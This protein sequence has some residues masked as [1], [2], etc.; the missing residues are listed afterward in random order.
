MY[1]RWTPM[2]C[3]VPGG[4][5]AAPVPDLRDLVEHGAHPA[6]PEEGAPE[7]VGVL[8]HRLRELV[9]QQLPRRRDLGAVDVADGARVEGVGLVDLVE[10]LRDDAEVVG[11]V[12][13]Q[14]EDRLRV[15]EVRS[16]RVAPSGAEQ[17]AEPLAPVGG[18]ARVALVEGEHVPAEVGRPHPRGGHRVDAALPEVVGAVP[19][20]LHGLA[21]LL[22]D[23]GGLEG[24]VGEQVAAEGAAALGHVHLHL[25]ER[26][27]EVQ[28]DLLLGP[29]RRLEARPDL[30]AVPAGRPQP[31]SSSP[32]GR[33]GGSGT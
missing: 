17:L 23:R 4:H 18:H 8:P 33:R 10:Q 7:L 9:D 11:H 6:V 13:G 20:Q 29:D 27:P 26:Q 5:R 28:G 22:G 15:A 19:H 16:G 31:R 2:P 1:S 30:G 3:A 21:Q 32:A 24:G 14:G 25:V 12:G